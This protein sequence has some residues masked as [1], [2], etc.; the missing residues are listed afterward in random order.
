MLPRWAAVVRSP[1]E[2]SKGPGGATGSTLGVESHPGQGTS[3][4]AVAELWHR[5]AVHTP[6]AG[7][8]L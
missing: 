6:E 7:G 1:T 5:R 4:L 2:G 3:L 8:M